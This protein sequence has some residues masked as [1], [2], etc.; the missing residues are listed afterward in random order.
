MTVSMDPTAPPSRA[1]VELVPA[2]GVISYPWVLQ[3][4]HVAVVA[5]RLALAAILL[6]LAFAVPL[7][8]YLFA[9]RS[10]GLGG[11]TVHQVR[12]RRLAYICV[13]APTLFVFLGVLHGL[14]HIPV[15][16]N[17][18]WVIGW[19]AF[20]IWA[21]LGSA[22]EFHH[23]SATALSRWRVV[24]G[25]SGAIILAYVIFHIGNH[26]F[27]LEGPAAHT[28]VMK[29]GRLVYRNPFIEPVLAAVLILQVFTGFRL[30]WRWSAMPADWH[31][32]FQ[33][34]SGFYLS[35]FILGHMNSVFIYA[36]SVRGI[37]TGWNF[38]TGA[39][40]GLIYD[41][42]NIRLLPHYALGVF[43]VLAHLASGLR[44]VL[45]AH[46]YHR[47]WV[48][49]AWNVGVAASFAISVAIIAGMCGLRI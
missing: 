17:A 7:I 43:L 45:L 33:I 15:S 41:A 39:P 32:V 40:T 10:A 22:G 44:V 38:A 4:F 46:G 13:V 37:D 14:A 20:A 9:V 2:V 5:E 34:A 30:A 31:R 24:H 48:G 27:G 6:T 29:A 21:W 12:M 23:Q 35:A 36:R 18:V 11:Q 19:T 16:D 42:W 8:S 28:A 26:L 25:I 49:P 3:A 47:R 1:V